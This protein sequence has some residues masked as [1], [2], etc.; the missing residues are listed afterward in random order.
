MRND[1]NIFMASKSFRHVNQNDGE[2]QSTRFA[3]NSHPIRP[4]GPMTS[5]EVA[6]K[7]HRR[8]FLR[9][10]GHGRFRQQRFKHE[11]G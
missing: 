10:N 8:T 1:G 4:K 3:I 9:T 11:T 2:A 6:E 5:Y 7:S